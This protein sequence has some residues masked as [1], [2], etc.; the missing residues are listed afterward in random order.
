MNGVADR[1]VR[2]LRVTH[3]PDRHLHQAAAVATQNDFIGLM[4]D[5][6]SSAMDQHASATAV[7]DRSIHGP[8]VPPVRV[9]RGGSGAGLAPKTVENVHRMLHRAAVDAVA[10]EYMVT[11]PAADSDAGYALVTDLVT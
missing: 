5:S 11:N 4:I 1:V 8:G 9:R 2:Q 3:G 7:S 6:C 10:Q